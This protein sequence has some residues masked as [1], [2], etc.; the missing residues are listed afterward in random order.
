MRESNSRRSINKERSRAEASKMISKVRRSRRSAFAAL[1]LL[2]GEKVVFE[3]NVYPTQVKR[4]SD[5]LWKL[6]RVPK[7]YVRSLWREGE[8]HPKAVWRLEF[9]ATKDVF[10]VSIPEDDTLHTANY[11]KDCD[12]EEVIKVPPTIF[13]LPTNPV[14]HPLRGLW[15]SGRDQ[16][17]FSPTSGMN[18][19]VAYKV[20]RS[21]AL[22][23]RRINSFENYFA[24]RNLSLVHIL[25]VGGFGIAVAVRDGEGLL[26]V[27]KLIPLEEEK[28]T[29]ILREI[30]IT[31]S[32]S[33]LKS[34]YGDRVGFPKYQNCAIVSAPLDSRIEFLLEDTKDGHYFVSPSMTKWLAIE[35][36]YGGNNLRQ[37]ARA[38]EGNLR[39]KHHGD[40]LSILA[41]VINTLAIAEAN[42]E[43]EH[44]DCHWENILILEE[45][46]SEC[47][48]VFLES[49]GRIHSIPSFGMKVMLIDFGLAR[50]RTPHGVEFL[51]VKRI[52]PAILQQSGSVQYDMYRRLS[53]AIGGSWRGFRPRTNALWI[54]YLV[55]KLLDRIGYASEYWSR[56]T[57]DTCLLENFRR[58]L[59][60]RSPRNARN[61]LD[62]LCSLLAG[63][64]VE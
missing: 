41:Q 30:F 27:L 60:D 8:C 29:H 50:C 57:D 24:A 2:E 32:V 37:Y 26:S 22:T 6:I 16:T 20:L 64:K 44:R 51:D 63:R 19:R 1:V 53:K 28:M 4:V 13:L 17:D 54:E 42:L 5:T 11:A 36:E 61:C 59:N 52:F 43:F 35:I 7:D 45:E 58:I 34:C 23:K 46:P 12:P 38:P 39:L 33:N 21:V 10:D 49:N 9:F 48:R 3:M 47:D 62:V 25:G 55:D 18:P 40:A 15:M 14:F 56:E 31:A